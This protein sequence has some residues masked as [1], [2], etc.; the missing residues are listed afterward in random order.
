[1]EVLFKGNKE[2]LS[3]N[4]LQVGDKMPEFTVVDQNLGRIYSRNLT[5]IKLYITVPSIDTRICSI[6]VAKFMTLLKD[7][8]LTCLS[9]SKDLPFALNRWCLDHISSNVI[10]VSD[11]LDGSFGL[12]S[13]TVMTQYNLL[14]RSIFL[15]DENNIVRYKQIVED[16]HTEP[17]YDAVLKAIQELY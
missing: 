2:P 4:Q 5:G 9:V 1:M 7:M 12:A 3:V 11:Y 10:A 13:G 14:A 8:K 15:V 17:D 6:E 16:T